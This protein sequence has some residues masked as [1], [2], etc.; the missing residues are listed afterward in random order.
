MET[1]GKTDAIPENP[2]LPAVCQPECVT[3]TGNL[4]L[5]LL[6]KNNEPEIKKRLS[7][8]IRVFS[9]CVAVDT[10]ST[11][12]TVSLLKNLGVQVLSFSFNDDFSE[13][14]NVYLNNIVR[15]K[16]VLTLD[17]DEFIDAAELNKLIHYLETVP[18]S[19]W[20]LSLTIA[21]YRQPEN[22][23]EFDYFYPANDSR[24]DPS[25]N[26]ATLSKRLIC[27]RSHEKIRYRGI[28]HESVHKSILEQGKEIAEADI[29]IHNY[30]FPESGE[31][32]KALKYMEL[33]KKQVRLTPQEAK[34]FYELGLSHRFF[35]ELDEAEDCFKKAVSLKKN[36]YLAW[37][38][39][40]LILQ[41]KKQYEEALQ[42]FNCALADP[43]LQGKS[44]YQMG[45]L[46]QT[47]KKDEEALK[48]FQL[49]LNHVKAK[50][51][52]IWQIIRFMEKKGDYINGLKW[53]DQLEKETPRDRPYL[54]YRAV[55]YA[56]AGLLE[57]AVLFFQKTFELDP[58]HIPSLYN[59]AVI[60]LRRNQI[61]E[62]L[63]AVQKILHLDPDHQDA[64]QLLLE[65]RRSLTGS[66]PL[67]PGNPQR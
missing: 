13:A 18:E 38:Y 22:F 55:F 67:P 39:L 8:L 44:L 5:C 41:E 53:F 12:Q 28:I 47:L 46:C 54:Y 65:I 3:H 34:P 30:G 14:R 31:N 27:F 1:G 21:I 59:Y 43:P 60:Q 52:V 35:R 15:T 25:Q 20:G 61:K 11:D 26:G 66:A 51:F 57:E 36:F 63:E 48:F 29:L 56:G 9:N 40:G 32:N 19:V 45:I 6:V 10:G 49:S 58:A 4:T 23:G 33:L 17:S 50:G 24:L 2:A 62:S 64:K 37:F 7:K 42:C 16:W